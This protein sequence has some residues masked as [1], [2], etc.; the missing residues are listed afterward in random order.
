MNAEI[1]GEMY[2]HYYSLANEIDD[3]SLNAIGWNSS[4]TGL[5]YSAEDMYEWRNNTVDIIRSL[6]PETVLEAACGTGMMMFRILN[7]V[8]YYVGIDISEKGIE[9]IKS[10]L[11][12]EEKKKTDFYVMS[13]E[14]I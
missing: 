3:F 10:H 12:D 2:N 11:N 13:V 1:I 8:K 14:D 4:F 7:E 5:P 9:F 6:K